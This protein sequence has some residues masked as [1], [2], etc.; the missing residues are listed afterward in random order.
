[1]E[2]VSIINQ[3]IN[4]NTGIE[5]ATQISYLVEWRSCHT[6]NINYMA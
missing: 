2:I 1:M 3:L 4:L 5:K 6:I